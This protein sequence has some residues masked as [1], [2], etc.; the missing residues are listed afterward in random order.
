MFA[1]L[2]ELDGEN[3]ASNLKKEQIRKGEKVAKLR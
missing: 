1:M 3:K 2:C